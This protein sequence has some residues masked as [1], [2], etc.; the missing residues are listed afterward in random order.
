MHPALLLALFATS[1][2][3]VPMLSTRV[4]DAAA[5]LSAEQ[6]ARLEARLADYEHQTGHQLAVVIVETLDGTP[7]EEASLRTVERWNRLGD[8]R[9]DDGLLFFIALRERQMRIEVGYGL[10]GAVPDVVA[11]RILRELVAPRLAAGDTGGAIAAGT[12]ALIA[13]TG[14]GVSGTSGAISSAD[15][16]PWADVGFVVL[17]EL[18]IGLLLQ[19]LSRMLRGLLVAA[20]GIGVGWVISGSVAVVAVGAVAGLVIGALP[21]HSMMWALSLGR[22]GGAG[23]GFSGRGGRFGGG[24]ATGRW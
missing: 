1:A 16:D 3:D 8:A 9:R 17:A 11:G 15:V 13:A 23:A 2:F 20:L 22:G 5:A 4:V 19:R 24:G 7:I 10:E 21:T 14:G 6:A 12:E 18:V